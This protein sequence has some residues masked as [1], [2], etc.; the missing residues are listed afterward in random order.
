MP[1]PTPSDPTSQRIVIAG[2]HSS[3]YS[4]K[5]RSVLRYRHIPHDWVM[6]NSRWDDLPDPPVAVIPVLA[7][8]DGDGGYRD[9]M[10]DS[11]P[12]ITRL[13]QEYS[14]RSVVPTDPAL[15]FLDFLLE[16]FGDEW[17]AKSMYHYRWANAEDTEMSGRLLPFDSN[18]QLADDR[19]ARAHDRF[20]DR[21]VGRRALVGSTDSNAPVIE[22]SF[23][24]ILDILQTHL[25]HHDFFFGGRPGRTDFALFGQLTPLLW[26][27]PTPTA[28]AVKRAPRAIMWVQW[29]DDLSWWRVDEGDAG[30]GAGR[31]FTADALP[32]TTRALLI[33]AGRTYAPFMI[34][35][36]DALVSGADEVVC[37]IDGHEYRQAPFKYQGKCLQWIR[38][39]Y[40]A[41]TEDDRLRV[42]ELL[43]G[44]GCEPLVAAEP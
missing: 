12:Q 42:D 18:L 10:V 36:T 17:L 15:A 21:Q 41:L 44:T 5:M 30:D 28:V 25:S 2:A 23:E 13:E 22:Q 43:A 6:R 9:V 39:Q 14:A 31:W 3:P 34:A 38:Q 32:Q 35:N 7:W 11:S 20:I 27:D 24:N 16:D 33:E 19:A 37:T 8:P 4:R 1:D 40:A 26:W 29:L